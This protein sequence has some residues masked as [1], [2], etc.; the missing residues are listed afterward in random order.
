M[1]NYYPTC[2]FCGERTLPMAEYE[3]QEYAD[4]AASMQC[5]CL[6]AK[7]HRDRELNINKIKTCIDSY[8]EYC[9]ARN[10]KYDDEIKDLL[11]ILSVN[12]LDD[13]IGIANIKL[14]R[15]KVTISKT[16]KGCVSINFVYSD[17]SKQEV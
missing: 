4:D 14:G 12:V 13:F 1:K 11:N 16:S 9:N 10:I 15:L 6:D 7:A 5:S 8:E 2:R 3:S 17:S